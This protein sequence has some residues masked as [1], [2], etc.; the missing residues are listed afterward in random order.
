[1]QNVGGHAEAH[2]PEEQKDHRRGDWRSKVGAA[3]KSEKSP[4]WTRGTTARTTEHTKTW[5][6]E[7]EFKT[8]RRRNGT[9]ST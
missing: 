9:S 8:N 4:K 3:R 2:A 6:A 7:A 5:G 1:M